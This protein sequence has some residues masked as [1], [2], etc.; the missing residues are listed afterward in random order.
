MATSA[1]RPEQRT[2]IEFRVKLNM[3]TIQ[4]LKHLQSIDGHKTVSPT[5]VFKWYKRFFKG[6]IEKISENV[7]RLAEIDG[8]L[9]GDVRRAIDSDR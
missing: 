2:V 6:W 4:Y 1:E 9:I 5:L 3:T 7:V 8:Q